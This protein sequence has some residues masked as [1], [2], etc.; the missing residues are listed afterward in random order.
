[1]DVSLNGLEKWLLDLD[2]K[3]SPDLRLQGHLFDR[4]SNEC[5]GLLGETS[6]FTVV[7]P[8]ESLT[9]R[10]RESAFPSATQYA[11]RDVV[12]K[13]LE[14][15]DNEMVLLDTATLAPTMQ[16]LIQGGDESVINSL[17]KAVKDVGNKK[18]VIRLLVGDDK[19]SPNK[20]DVTRGGFY[21][22]NIKTASKSA[23]KKSF[24]VQSQRTN[25]LSPTYPSIFHSDVPTLEP[26]VT[27]YVGHYC[28]TSSQSKVISAIMTCQGSRY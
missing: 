4:S 15:I 27:L 25:P 18:V 14:R 20:E 19:L 10:N 6:G 16:Y 11:F 24:G 7:M 9:I 5:L 1:M 17:A 8:S 3:F 21:Q 22:A 28:Q 13:G 26:D 2:G 12:R 23:T